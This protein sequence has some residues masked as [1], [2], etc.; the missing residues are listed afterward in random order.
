MTEQYDELNNLYDKL[1]IENHN[2]I[3]ENNNKNVEINKLKNEL[4][5]LL[6][7]KKNR[8]HIT[9]LFN[10]ELQLI[11]KTLLEKDRIILELKK[12]NEKLNMKKK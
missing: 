3:T 7:E 4:V 8:E 5:S 6:I 12:E 2:V 10:M 9:N 1:L 11:N